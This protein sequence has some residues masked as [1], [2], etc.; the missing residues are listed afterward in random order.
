MFVRLF[1]RSKNI[2]LVH[3]CCTNLFA[4]YFPLKNELLCCSRLNASF[5]PN[6][7]LLV[8]TISMRMNYKTERGKKKSCTKMEQLSISFRP[9]FPTRHF[10]ASIFIYSYKFSAHLVPF[11]F[12]SELK[13][14]PTTHPP[15]KETQIKK[16]KKKRK[17]KANANSP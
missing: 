17:S 5:L 8:I 13:K 12:F 14:N 10:S 4:L 3:F 15:K 1:F 2:F 16:L 11:N 6:G 7:I 9:H